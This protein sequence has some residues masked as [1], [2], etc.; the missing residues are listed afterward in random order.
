MAKAVCRYR[1]WAPAVNRN[2]SLMPSV[3]ALYT[4]VMGDAES[5]GKLDWTT[6]ITPVLDFVQ[7]KIVCR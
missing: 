7:V 2:V 6:L 4:Q 1:G 3:A 5:N